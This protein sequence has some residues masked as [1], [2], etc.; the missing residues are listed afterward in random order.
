MSRR[1]TALGTIVALL[2]ASASV[3]QTPAP[4]ESAPLTAPA[5]ASPAPEPSAPP[6]TQPPKPAD[7]ASPA[8]A[9][10]PPVPGQAAPVRSARPTL[11]PNPGDP[12]DIETVTLPVKP[13]A[14]FKG[15]S[16]WDEGYAELTGAFR[17]L[18]EA[19]ARAGVRPAGRPLAAF[20][21]TDDSG[22][23]FEAMLPVDAAPA[24][25]DAAGPGVTFGS[26][27]GGSALRFVHKGAYDDI[28]STYETITAYLDAKGIEAGDVFVE[29]YVTDVKDASDGELE[30]NV[31]VFPK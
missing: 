9:A 26:N 5:P 15:Q 20:V 11:L 16:T 3:A 13:V 14:I 29:E 27:R 2:C 31:F 18:E 12:D 30:I 17:K 4:V 21:S 7:A 10:Q 22:F 1:M 23:R 6:V 25:P 24:S 19:A 28:D 8:P